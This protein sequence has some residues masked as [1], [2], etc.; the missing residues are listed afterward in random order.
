M[1]I[2][3]IFIIK[4]TQAVRL[5]VFKIEWRRHNKQNLTRVHTFFPMEQVTVGRY[6]YGILNVVTYGNSNEILEIGDFCSIAEDVK[7]ILGGEHLYC[8]MSTYP[9]KVN[10]MGSASEVVTKGPIIIRDD[11]WIG[12]NSIILSGTTIGQGAIIAAG[13]IVSKDVPPYAIYTTNKIIKYRFQPEIIEMML[14]I[15]FSKLDKRFIQSNINLLYKDV[16]RELFNNDE[17]K[18]LIGP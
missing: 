17:V 3:K 15:D 12:S 10:I 14:K 2:F 9:F 7:F 1:N 6:T 8:G 4:F 11:V 18:K 13:S 16:N 5:I